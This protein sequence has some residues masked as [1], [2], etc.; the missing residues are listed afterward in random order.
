MEVLDGT[1]D[2]RRVKETL[3]AGEA[4]PVARVAEELAAR[5]VLH[6]A[7]EEA[8][9]MPRPEQPD[10]ERVDDFLQDRPLNVHVLLL[11]QAMTSLMLI[12]LRAK[13]CLAVFFFTGSTRPNIP[14]PTVASVSKSCRR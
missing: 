9:V 7:V 11:L 2:L 13:K 10:E 5:Q 12:T 1:G 14:V 3:G 6:E 4:P 8:L